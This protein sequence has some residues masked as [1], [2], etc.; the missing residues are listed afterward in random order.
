MRHIVRVSTNFK[1]KPK[2]EKLELG[3]AS[4]W[5]LFHSSDSFLPQFLVG[6]RVKAGSCIASQSVSLVSQVQAEVSQAGEETLRKMHNL[7]CSSTPMCPIS[8][9]HL[10]LWGCAKSATHSLF[11]V[12]SHCG[13]NCCVKVGFTSCFAIVSMTQTGPQALT[14]RAFWLRVGFGSGLTKKFEFWVWVCAYYGIKANSLVILCNSISC[15]GAEL[16][17]E[18]FVFQIMLRKIWNIISIFGHFL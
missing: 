12:C 10:H 18:C 17:R 5:W 16:K 7:P 14:S 13:C 6:P 4:T 1:S 15:K 11:E 2:E 3:F 9:L 8:N